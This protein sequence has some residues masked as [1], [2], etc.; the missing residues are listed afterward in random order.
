MSRPDNQ[1]A[2]YGTVDAP[3]RDGAAIQ[4]SG[5]LV[6]VI[7]A[8]L[9]EQGIHKMRTVQGS[10]AKLRAQSYDCSRCTRAGSLLIHEL[11]RAKRR[12]TRER[13]KQNNAPT[14]FP[15]RHSLSPVAGMFLQKFDADFSAGVGRNREL[16]VL[17]G[18]VVE[19]SYALGMPLPR[20]HL[21][22]VRRE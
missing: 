17:N 5:W 13:E 21:V 7:E 15:T 20:L 12:Q 9:L 2:G 8:D 6:L 10:V 4:D 3:E 22:G 16:L 19:R 18:R 1:V 14:P 11:R